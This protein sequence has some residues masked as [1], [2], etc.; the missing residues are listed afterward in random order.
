MLSEEKGW[1]QLSEETSND[2]DESCQEVCKKNIVW[3]ATWKK[4]LVPEQERVL[5]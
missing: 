3:W 1:L 2:Q 4:H 5:T